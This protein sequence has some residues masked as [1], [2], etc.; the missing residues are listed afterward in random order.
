MKA[1]VKDGILTITTP[2]D[3]DPQTSK[4]GKSKVV[5]SSRGIVTTDLMIEGKPL[6]IGLNAFIGN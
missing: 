1:T 6:R 4:S 5:A 3:K 2:I